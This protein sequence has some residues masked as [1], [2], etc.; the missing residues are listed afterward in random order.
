MVHQQIYPQ[1]H[2]NQLSEHVTSVELTSNDDFKQS[3]SLNCEAAEHIGP[4]RLTAAEFIRD[5]LP[6]SY[7][8]TKQRILSD[9]A[10][11]R[12][13]EIPPDGLKIISGN[14]PIVHNMCIIKRIRNASIQPCL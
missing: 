14:Y 7:T 3:H 8:G 2:V 6:I 4:L 9:I 5:L 12:I 13:A 10:C 1:W 11:S